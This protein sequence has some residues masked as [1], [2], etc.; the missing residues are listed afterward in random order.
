[1]NIAIVAFDAIS[2][3]HLSVPIAV[4]HD[5]MAIDHEPYEVKVCTEQRRN[6]TTSSGLVVA[7]QADW[8]YIAKADMVIFPS[9]PIDLEINDALSQ[10]LEVA[11]SRGVTLVGLC[12]GAFALGYAGVLNGKTATSHWRYAHEFADKFPRVKFESNPLYIDAENIVTSAGS[13]AAIDCCLYLLRKL[14]GNNIANQVA[15]MMVAAPSRGG[16]Q[17]QFIQQPIPARPSDSRLATFIDYVVNHI[18]EP[19]SLTHAA[20]HCAM[21]V[22]S[23]NRHFQ[24]SYG[25]GFTQWLIHQRLNYA[26]LLLE[27]SSLSITNVA[28]KAGFASEQM[29]RKHFRKRFDTLPT[30]W[31][32]AFNIGH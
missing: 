28:E 13:A 7:A 14:R 32:K 4:F 10:K 8:D 30:Q 17:N 5:A 15:R 23:F 29:F 20:S 22:R 26:L 27:E 11:T 12:T 3:F 19:Y 31:R 9:W 18:G 21:S 1:M 6:I 16:G 25:V 2:L 24:K